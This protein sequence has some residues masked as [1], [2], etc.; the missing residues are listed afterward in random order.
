[1]LMICSAGLLAFKAGRF[2]FYYA[3][4]DYLLE[5]REYAVIL[6]TD[7][8]LEGLNPYAIELQPLAM[9]VYGILL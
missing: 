3:I 1:M 9:D 8:L 6:S 4:Q 5:Y 2:M 7:V